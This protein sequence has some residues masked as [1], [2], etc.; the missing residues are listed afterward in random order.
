[1]RAKA[2]G[3]LAAFGSESSFLAGLEAVRAA[4]FSRLET[5]APHSVEEE[6]GILGFGPSPVRWVMLGAGAVGGVGAFAM[7]WYAAV[8]FPE[9]VGGRP[10][11]SWPS[12]VPITFELTILCA[13]LAG[14]AAMLWLA[15]LPRL[16]HP[17]FGVPGFDRASQDRY[18]I[19]VLA[20]DA[21]YSPAAARAALEPA[22]PLSTQEVLL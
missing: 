9:D 16:D 12:F 10:L 21:R 7:Q 2:Y 5:Y 17:L 13:C 11:F 20:D 1:M 14:A 4:G 15:G 18:F 19:C 22:G 3:L 6:E 8:D